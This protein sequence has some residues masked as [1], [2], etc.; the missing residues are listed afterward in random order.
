MI[1]NSSSEIGKLKIRGALKD[2]PALRLGLS[3]LIGNADLNPNGLSPSE[4]LM[5]KHMS[6]PL[7]GKIPIGKHQFRPD[8]DWQRAVQDQLNDIYRSAVRPQHGMISGNAEAVV[9]SDQAELLACFSIDLARGLAVTHWWWRHLLKR[10]PVNGSLSRVLCSMFGEDMSCLPAV[11]ELLQSWYLSEIVL[12]VIDPEDARNL[13]IAMVEAFG[14]KKL[15]VVLEGKDLLEPFPVYKTESEIKNRA[16][17]DSQQGESKNKLATNDALEDGVVDSISAELFW[18]QWLG[19]G[20]LSR[21]LGRERMFLLGLGLLLN[22]TP[23]K[24]SSSTLQHEFK[25]AW[26]NATMSENSYANGTRADQNFSLSLIDKTEVS[27]LETPAEILSDLLAVDRKQ[28]KSHAGDQDAG[29]NTTEK[30]QPSAIPGEETQAQRDETQEQCNEATASPNQQGHINKQKSVSVQAGQHDKGSHED[31]DSTLD[32]TMPEQLVPENRT[33]V[34]NESLDTFD[35]D[36]LMSTESASVSNAKVNY[37]N[38]V[39]TTDIGGVL[40]LINLMNMLDLPA[41]FEQDWQLASRVGPWAVLELLGRALLDEQA[42]SY[43]EDPLWDLL[44]KLDGRQTGESPGGSFKGIKAFRLPPAWFEQLRQ[45]RETYRWSSAKGRLR[46]WSA[47]GILLVDIPRSEDSALRQAGYE[48]Q[49]YQGEGQPLLLS[50]SAHSKAPI[51]HNIDCIIP[52]IS[53]ALGFCLKS[54]M[55]GIRFRLRQALGNEVTQTVLLC[56]A[57]IYFSSSHVDLQTNLDNISLAA[58]RAGL[59]QDPGW[60]PGMGKVVLFHFE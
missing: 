26:L 58:R 42:D 48:L 49:Y 38:Q 28:Q 46:L 13:C 54:V 15:S 23:W 40:Y 50:R 35:Q 4:I 14:F 33:R 10:N 5:I 39:I 6:D 18:N 11:L 36:Q 31:Q 43:A 52:G 27:V 24:V 32:L 20:Q 2:E 30:K 47:S 29:F 60:M 51:D 37:A 53:A 45:A 7:P 3:N 16:S 34:L 44:A 8:M 57:K 22:R 17:S 12:R 1:N 19:S 25:Q 55:S 21:E 9:F 56:R 59:D 41:C